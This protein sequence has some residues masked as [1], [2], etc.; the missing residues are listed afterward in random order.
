MEIRCRRRK[1]TPKPAVVQEQTGDGMG[2]Q[3][4]VLG[5]TMIIAGTAIGAGML[6]LPMISAGMWIYWSL[7]LMVLTWMLMLRASQAILEVNLHYE[8][9]SSFHTLVQDTLGPVWSTINGL[10]VAFV[11]YILVYAYVSGGG[12]TVQQTVMAV[13]GNDPGMM[14][15]SLFFS[16]ILMA[17]VWW[18]TR[19]VDRLSVI[20]MGGMVLTFILS[21]TGMLSQIRLP[22]L[23]DLGENGSGGGAAIFIWCALS[24]YLTSFCFHASVPSLVKYFGKRPADINKCLRYGTLIALVCYVAWI[25]AADGIISRGQFKAVIAAGGNVGDL[26]RA[27][28]S[29]IDSSFILRM[30][31]AFSFFAVATSFLGAGLGLF[32]YMA[33]LCK[34]D[35]SVMGRAKTTLVTFLPPLLGGLISRTASSPPSDGRVSPQPSGRSSSRPSCCGPAA[36]SSRRRLW[37]PGRLFDHLC[38][39]CIRLH[40]R[41]VPY[42]FRAALSAHVRIGLPHIRFSS[43]RSVDREDFLWVPWTF[44]GMRGLS[45]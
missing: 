16:L 38:P 23:L 6:A 41:R 30:L 12:S 31:E 28:G 22:V 15:S 45:A 21:M 37:R 11:L 3:G 29:G 33:D 9:G 5:G 20:L 2:S 40:Y 36:R 32:D 35:D 34:F 7:L 14:G 42:P 18:S 8:P 44:S 27:A 26:I 24:T 25:V 4:N 43:S 39:A 10:A 1:F 19:F 13:T 17:C